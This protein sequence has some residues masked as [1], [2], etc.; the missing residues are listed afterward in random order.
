MIIDSLPTVRYT[1]Q[2]HTLDST[3]WQHFVPRQD[4]IIVATSYKSGTTW[5]LEIVHRLI[6]LDATPPPN[7]EYWIDARWNSLDQMMGELAAQ[8]RQRLIKT[9]LPL[10]GLPYFPQVKYIVVGRDARDVFMSLWN[11]YAKYT[12]R[13]YILINDTPG[14][15]G[16]RLPACPE[17][18]HEFWR[19]W[20]TRGWFAWEREG[21]PFWSN[22]HHTQTWWD[23]RSLKNILFVHFNDLL[24]D[25]AGEIRRIAHFLGIVISEAAI[26]ALVQAV[27]LPS[28]RR[29]AETLYPNLGQFWQGGVQTFYFK[30]TNG[31]WKE[32]LSEDELALYTETA[33]QVLAPDCASWLAQGREALK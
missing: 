2:N 18:I 13:F 7:Q 16:A 23:Y 8:D 1:Y 26:V 31:R 22:L 30:G 25:L 21:Y 33:D 28:M 6:F 3:R 5:M 12:Q 27:S 20:I 29:E 24:L 11:H 32:I 9:H 15:V 19:N 4:D 10:D 14:R 17:S